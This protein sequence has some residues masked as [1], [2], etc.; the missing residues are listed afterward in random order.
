MHRRYYFEYF[1]AL[2]LL[3]WIEIIKKL[4]CFLSAYKL[5]M[6]LPFTNGKNNVNNDKIIKEN[7]QIMVGW[8]M[9]SLFTFTVILITFSD[10]VQNKINW[11]YLL[12]YQNG[13]I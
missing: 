2:C 8:K 7:L 3:P 13:R 1:N 6:Q 10:V 5:T 4:K 9:F 11:I 12:L